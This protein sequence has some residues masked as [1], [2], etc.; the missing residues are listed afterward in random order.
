MVHGRAYHK[1][2]SGW[3]SNRTTDRC[4]GHFQNHQL[5]LTFDGRKYFSPNAETAKRVLD[6]GTGT[7]IWAI[8]FADEHPHAE[9]RSLSECR[10]NG[11]HNLWV[12]GVDI[13]PIQPGLVPPNLRFEVDDVEKPWTWTQQFDY[14]FVRMLVGSLASWEPFFKQAYD[15]LEPGGWIELQDPGTPSVSDDGTLKDRSPLWQHDR[16]F[17]QSAKN[18]GRPIHLAADHDERLKDAGFINVER[19]VFKWPINTWPKNPKHKEVGLWT[20]ANIEGNLETISMALMT[21]GLGI[22]REEVEAF[23]VGV[24]KD[25]RDRRIHA[26]WPVY[27]TIGQKPLL[28]N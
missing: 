2:E 14:I 24:R 4:D 19:K 25:L 13:A 15:T 28:E 11:T 8:D 10:L 3:P 6:V 22:T 16:R 27:V 7:G 23:L 18:L 26:Y 12:V 9:V 17:I 20:L 5:L 21:R 1:D